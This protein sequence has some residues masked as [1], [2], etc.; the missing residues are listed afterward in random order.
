VLLVV[1]LI[2]V[3]VVV[4]VVVVDRAVNQLI[5]QQLIEIEIKKQASIN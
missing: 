5:D 3:V 4:V 1:V 2:V